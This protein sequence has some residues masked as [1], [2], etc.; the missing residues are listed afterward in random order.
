MTI[1]YYIRRLIYYVKYDTI[2]LVG[3]NNVFIMRRE[4]D[5]LSTENVNAIAFRVQWLIQNQ[6]YTPEQVELIL[7]YDGYFEG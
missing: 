1:N 7:E 2:N 4:V 6:G 3:R 5:R